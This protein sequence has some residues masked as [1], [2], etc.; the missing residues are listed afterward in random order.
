MLLLVL[1]VLSIALIGYKL[2]E[3]YNYFFN[4]IGKLWSLLLPVVYG[5]I[6]AYILNPL[7][8]FIQRKFKTKD[9][10]AILS[11]YVLL[12]VILVVV[13]I[14]LIP[15]MVNS[16][17]DLTSNIPSYI[18]ECQSWMNSLLNNKEI[19]DIITSTGIMDNINDLISKIGTI[20]V[21]I[22]EGAISYVVTISSQVVKLFIGLLI[23]I[24]VLIDKDR[25]IR[26]SKK[27]TFLVVK[28]KRAVKVIEAIRIYHS[29]VGAYIG[30]KAI[31]STIIGFM[32]LI[33]LTIVKSE[34][35]FLL[36][37]IVGITN[38]IPY[39]GPFIGEVVGFLFNVF[40]SPSKGLIVFLVLLA[41]QQFDGWYLD[42][43]LIGDK[44]GVRPLLIIVAVLIGGG[45]FGALG[46]LL[47]SPTA[48]TIKIYYERLMIKNKEIIKNAEK[49]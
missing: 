24:Y 45:F 28:E 49:V 19:Q 12:I 21:S 32:A 18:K 22:L 11:S 15:N 34:Y 46:M 2:I 25:I 23:S 6:I 14:F 30:I 39:F 13:A 44:V 33:L 42:P 31:D 37:I 4:I 5:L 26:E 27:L 17:I 43:K 8:K 29:M 1:L 38:M 48:A 47:A 35:A 3:N 40:V 41:L 9:G 16:L 7:V 10:I 20:S 36:A